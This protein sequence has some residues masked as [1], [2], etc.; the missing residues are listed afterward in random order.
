MAG[1][2][3]KDGPA[4]RGCGLPNHEG[5]CPVCRGDQQEAIHE[6]MWPEPEQEDEEIAISVEQQPAKIPMLEIGREYH[7][8][9]TDGWNWFG[10]ER[11]WTVFIEVTGLNGVGGY[12]INEYWRWNGSPNNTLHNIRTLSLEESIQLTRD[13]LERESAKETTHAE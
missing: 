1:N 7:W 8:K 4:C 10:T 12:W 3:V 2:R 13:I 5:L 9:R 11:W 6:R